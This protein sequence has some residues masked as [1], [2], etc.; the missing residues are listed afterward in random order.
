MKLTVFC[1][2]KGLSKRKGLNCLHLLKHQFKPIKNSKRHVTTY[3]VV[4]VL[5]N[6]LQFNLPV[7]NQLIFNWAYEIQQSKQSYS[8]WTN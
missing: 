3:F 2:N 1:L 6:V 7:L 8:G 5:H 4:L